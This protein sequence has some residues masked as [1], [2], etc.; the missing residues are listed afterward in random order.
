MKDYA[1]R[2]TAFDDKVRL[3]ACRTTNL[4]EELH[5]RHETSATIS[6]ALGRIVS[7]AAMMGL[8]HKGEDKLMIQVHGD[9][10]AGKFTV[11]AD[12]HGNVR[13]Y[14][15]N[16]QVDFPAREG[17]K[18]DVRRAVGTT[19]MIYVTKDIGLRDPYQ[20]ASEIISGEIGEDFTYY[21]TTSEQVPSAVGVG[22]LVDTDLS[23]LAAGG[24]IIQ[25]MP[26]CPDEVI[27]IIEDRV[28]GFGDVSRRLA[29][30]E[31]PEEL[32]AALAADDVKIL[33]QHDINHFCTCNHDK[34]KNA[35]AQ[36]DLA[37][38]E[39]MIAEDGQA[40]GCC[41]FCNEKYIVTEPEL[42]ELCQAK[43]VK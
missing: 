19:G 29:A 2:G 20:G 39:S 3:L 7:V 24:F 28:A 27:S 16:P 11:D 30:G 34:I 14:V 25:V 8:L 42:H 31:S 43:G 9:G 15:T 1:V 38:I 33:A 21:F 18:L 10:P 23:I 4:V 26:D 37:E 32:L 6:A 17:G 35:I 41:N 22:V 5:C 36:F 40:E 13:G 12:A